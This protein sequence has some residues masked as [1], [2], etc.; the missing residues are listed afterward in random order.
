MG[1]PMTDALLTVLALQSALVALVAAWARRERGVAQAK[2]RDAQAAL[3]R[4]HVIV[5]GIDKAIL[6]Q[7][8][9]GEMLFANEAAA[10]FVGFPSVDALLGASQQ[11]FMRRVE[12][13][14]EDG[15]PLPPER[16]PG[17]NAMRTG[18][19]VERTILLRVRETGQA[20]WEVAQSY[21]VR[22]AD[23]RV[24]SVITVLHD[25]T[26]KR[27]EEA[28]REELFREVER[29]R[30]E[31]EA[32][33][34]SKDEFLAMLGHELRNPLAPI[35]TALRLMEMRGESALAR[36]R[37]V[38]ERQVRHLVRLVDDLLDISRITRGRIE[39]RKRPVELAD[40]VAR[41][42]EVSSPL[43][44]QRAQHLSVD[45]P[46]GLCV[47]GDP[48]RL[49]QVIGNLLTNASKYSEK[50]GRIDVA[51]ARADGRVELR[52]RDR[53]IGIAP[54]MLPRVFDLFAQERQALDRAQGG[55]GLGLAIVKSLVALHGGEVSAASEGVG[56]GSEF[57]VALPAFDEEKAPTPPPATRARA[58]RPSDAPGRVLVVDDNV[59][60]A[61][62]LAEALR[63]QGHEV[64]VAHDGPAA[65][66][67]ASLRPPA[68][69]LLDIGLPVMDGYELARRLRAAEGLAHVRLVA[70]TGYGQASDRERSRANGFDEHLVK[71]V[72]LDALSALV[73]RLTTPPGPRTA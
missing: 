56:R 41:G 3:A 40:A 51:G 8:V 7:G 6:V 65:L 68:L 20:R 39:L 19:A 12:V 53:G 34:R 44:E 33:S 43:I 59:D 48:E 13:L 31:A 21:P 62:S 57:R 4:L 37:T 9:Q 18:R 22:D 35:L 61:E 42:I 32:A 10:R 15:R 60:A 54:E 24:R 26:E 58:L 30:A 5:E 46:R 70:V 27:R 72:D 69:A 67:L 16:M 66:A 52:V 71:P 64:D 45:V 11:E 55:L 14:D 63:A 17:R 25:V 36:E 2:A 1:A 38:I 47:L 23:G 28:R 50:G 29:A 49:A 73:E